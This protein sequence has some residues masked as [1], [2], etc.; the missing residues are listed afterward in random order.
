MCV[1]RV[2]AISV[3]RP[4]L[5]R[6][7]GLLPRQNA[8][9][10]VHKRSA[11]T[12]YASPESPCFNVCSQLA[13][14]RRATLGYVNCVCSRILLLSEQTRN[15]DSALLRA[16]VKAMQQVLGVSALQCSQCSA[17]ACRNPKR[18]CGRRL[19]GISAP[20]RCHSGPRD[21][22]LRQSVAGI[23]SK[24]CCSRLHHLQLLLR[25]K[26]G[27]TLRTQAVVPP[28]LPALR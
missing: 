11:A 28:D 23:A 22:I 8:A 24:V 4:S 15:A 25:L 1:P 21:W 13:D 7:R 20:S 3:T 5:A 6:D 12:T 18:H 19:P 26:S 17:L 16:Q 27:D 14:V 10:S 9:C 2:W